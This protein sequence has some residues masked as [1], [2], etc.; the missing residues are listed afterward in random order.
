MLERSA[1]LGALRI[2]RE[3]SWMSSTNRAPDSPESRRSSSS[4]P[5][6][7]WW[8]IVL[9]IAI[10]ATAYVVLVLIGHQDGAT[11]AGSL[12]ALLTGVLAVLGRKQ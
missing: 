10:T 11:T 12:G 2:V 3:A 4:D 7:P 5:H 9:L 1:K 8:V 6:I